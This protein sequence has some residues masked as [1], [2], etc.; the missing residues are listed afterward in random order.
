MA[1]SNSECKYEVVKYNKKSP[2]EIISIF[3]AAPCKNNMKHFIV[4]LM[5]SII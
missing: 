1:V 3:M 2:N 4:Q 5:H